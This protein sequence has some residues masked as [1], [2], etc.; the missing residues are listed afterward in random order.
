MLT[1]RTLTELPP[2]A[3]AVP[4]VPV[5]GVVPVMGVEPAAAEGGVGTEVAV[6]PIVVG[7]VLATVPAGAEPISADWVAVEAAEEQLSELAPLCGTDESAI[8]MAAAGRVAAMNQVLKRMVI[9]L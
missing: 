7:T 4:V 2:V 6:D 5:V 3:P 1:G 9:L 8:P